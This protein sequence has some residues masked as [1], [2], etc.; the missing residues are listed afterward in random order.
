MMWLLVIVMVIPT[1]GV[2]QTYLLKHGLTQ[3]QCQVEQIRVSR[4]MAEAYPGDQDYWIDCR[5]ASSAARAPAGR[6]SGR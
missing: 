2:G 4:D 6:S 1:G 5:Q 3:R